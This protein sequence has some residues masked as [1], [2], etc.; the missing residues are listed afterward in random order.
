MFIITSLWIYIIPCETYLAIFYI[1]KIYA[2]DPIRRLYLSISVYRACSN[3]SHQ[4]QREFWMISSVRWQK[5]KWGDLL[6]ISYIKLRVV[7]VL[8]SNSRFVFLYSTRTVIVRKLLDFLRRL[9]KTWST[10]ILLEAANEL[11]G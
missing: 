8:L 5:F 1:S 4:R 6:T 11:L 10:S 3:F 7:N 2:H 9:M